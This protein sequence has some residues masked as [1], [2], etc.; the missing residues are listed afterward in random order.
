[1]SLK[2]VFIRSLL[3]GFLYPLTVMGL[4][5]VIGLVWGLFYLGFDLSY[6]TIMRWFT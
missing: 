1:M 5:F 6:G 4:G 3:L 2:S